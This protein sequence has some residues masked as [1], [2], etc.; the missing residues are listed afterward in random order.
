M[1]I[2]VDKYSS[3]LIEK[4]EALN[5]K[6]DTKVNILAIKKA[7]FYAKKVSRRSNKR[8]GEPFYS[9]P[10]AVA[11]IVADYIFDTEVIIIAIFH[12]II[13]DTEVTEEMIRVWFGDRIAKG[14]ERL[15]KIKQDKE[16]SSAEMIEQMWI[17]NNKE[18]LLTTKQF[19]DIAENLI[20]I[21][22]RLMLYRLIA[23]KWKCKAGEVDLICS[24]GENVGFYRS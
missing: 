18:E 10:F 22:Y 2:E 12:D 13:E 4:L 5:L 17:K 11:E 1:T 19:G 3:K 7:M 23:R 15:T 16:I 6:K 14:V 8:I 9:H 20:S 21:L 24:R